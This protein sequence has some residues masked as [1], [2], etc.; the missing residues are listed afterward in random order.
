MA[1]TLVSQIQNKNSNGKIISNSYFSDQRRIVRHQIDGFDNFIDNKIYEILDEYNSNSKNVIYADYDKELERNKLEYHIKFG[2]IY[3]SRPIIQDDQSSIRQMFPNDARLQKLTYSLTLKVDIY[4][5]LVEYQSNGQ[6]KE[7]EFTPLLAH[8]LGKIPLMLQSKYCVLHDTSNETLTEMGE[9]K[10]DYGGYFIVNGNEKVIVALER[11]AENIVYCFHQG[12]TQNKFSHKCEIRSVCENSPYNIKNAEVKLTAKDITSGK[13]IK[14]KIQGMRQEL[15]LFVVFRALG[16]ISDKQIVNS[17][18]YNLDDA[19]VAPYFELL[20]PSIEEASQIRDQQT[21]LEY[22]SKYVILQ[23]GIKQSA[24]QSSIYKISQT[25]TSIIEEFLPHLGNNPFKKSIFLGYMTFRLLQ[26]YLNNDYADRDSFMNKRVDTTGE[27]LASLFRINFKKMM[28]DVEHKCRQ[29]LQRHRFDE[30]AS[31]LHRKIKK[32][33]I[34]SG[35]KYGLSTGNWGLQSKDNKKGI[36][37]MLNR[38]SYLSFL[39]DMRK[40][41]APMKATM[42]NQQPRLLHSTQWGRICPAETPEGAPVGIVKNL[43]MLAVIT[44]GSSTQPIREFIIHLGLKQIEDIHSETIYG[45]CKVFINGDWIGIHEKP[46]VLLEEL[47]KMRRSGEIN[48]YTSISWKIQMNEIHIST[49]GGRL[50]RPLIII[51]NN[52]SMATEEIL[53]KLNANELEWDD[54]LFG[55]HVCI[56]YLDVAEENTAMIAMNP[57]DLDGNLR[58]NDKF[59]EYTHIEIDP[60]LMFGIIGVNGPFTD[61]QQAPRVIYYCAQSKQAVGIYS[62]TYENRFDT[63]GN[64]LYYPQKGLIT[65]DNS[66]YTNINKIPNGQN[67]VVAIMCY[68]GYNQEDSVIVNKSSL[69]R[70]MFVSTYFRTYEGKE[71]K[72]QSTLEEEKFCKPVKYNPNG[73]PRTAGMKEGSSYGKLEESGFVKEG[74][75][76]NGGD[77]IIGK[78]IPLKTTTDDEIKYRDSSTFVKSTDSGIVDKV[79]VNKDGEG[80]KFG[81][82]RVRSERIPEIGD[83][84]CLKGDCEVLTTVGWVPI[85]EIGMDHSVATLIDGRI[86]YVSPEEVYSFRYAGAMYRVRSDLVDLDTTVDH[87]LYVMLDGENDYRRIRAIEVLGKKY[88]FKKNCEKDGE[89]VQENPIVQFGLSIRNGR[90]KDFPEWVWALGK[91]QSRLLLDRI[92]DGEYTTDSK[93]FADYLMRLS[94]HAG[95]SAAIIENNGFYRVVLNK[96]ENEPV[97]GAVNESVY[98]YEGEVYCLRVPSHVFMVRQNMKNVWVGNCSR[99]ANKSTCG[100][101]FTQ[102][103][104]PYTK[105]GVVPD[106]IINPIGFPK[107]MTIGQ[108]IETVAGKMGAMKGYSIDGTPFTKMDPND[109]GAILEK[110]CGFQRNGLEVLYN[111]RTGEQI[112]SMIFVGPSYYHRLKHMVADKIHC[113]KPDHDVLTLAG[114]KAIPEITA[115]DEIACLFKGKLVYQRP[116][117]V[118]HYPDYKGKMYRVSNQHVDLD[119]TANHRMYVSQSRKLDEYEFVRADEIEGKH[120]RYKKS[121]EWDAPDYQF[122]LPVFADKVEKALDM[123]AW[124]IF[125]GIWIADGWTIDKRRVA[126][127][128]KKDSVKKVFEEAVKKLGYEVDKVSGL[129]KWTIHDAQLANY[130]NEL[131]VGGNNKFLPEWAFK[132]SQSQARILVESMILSDG[133]SVLYSTKSSRLANQFSQLCLHAGWSATKT[134]HIQKGDESQI[135]ERTRVVSNYDLFRVSVNKKFNNP[136]VNRGHYKKKDVKEDEVYDYEGPVHCV[137][138][139][140]NVFMVRRNGKPVWTANSR[141]SGP[142]SQLVRQPS[143]GRARDGGLRVGEMEKD[144]MLSHGTVQFLKERMFDV[145]DKYFVTLCKDTGMIAAVNKEKN[146]YNSLYSNNNTDFVRVQIPYAS[147]LLMQELYTIGIVMKLKTDAPDDGDKKKAK[148]AKEKEIKDL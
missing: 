4:H 13:T 127:Y 48:I 148:I 101:T 31:T 17:I 137:E 76:V 96:D 117:N 40:V 131:A 56:E 84:F 46:A 47:R 144:A 115:E 50:I 134:T 42:K 93:I 95:I 111:G 43:A 110:E 65:T 38:L 49:E 52:K 124:L 91:K 105:D 5:K 8:Q 125:M 119:T 113:L 57:E 41:Q 146:I 100:I 120:V 16:I 72:N 11:Q 21:A 98:H 92:M 123:E 133:N 68:T 14:V 132:L 108:L 25:R 34:E 70:G 23:G 79:Y 145:S 26:S 53:T 86:E 81:R 78:C 64:V 129:K 88:Q 147:K 103:D 24:F 12:K 94:I 130:M 141:S 99:Y 7:T 90:E 22:C 55:K 83:K 62:T 82:V 60:N 3:I 39:S 87:D 51:E 32:S 10:Y 9:D 104:M 114:W 85:R 35:M 71:Q 138:V 80:F 128:L 102:E 97:V 74:T 15:P 69:D 122:I 107:R 28:R 45:K 73:T 63:S 2:K 139:E 109:L 54:L 61:H 136:E 27:N 121:A 1:T 67:I 66:E 106:L 140:G 29:E 143:V 112:E 30:I 118:F 89:F 116:I 6:P 36:A 135:N 44:I 58:E 20:R 18:L 142:Y 37:R 77:A 75:R 59:F 19:E 33:D 126:I